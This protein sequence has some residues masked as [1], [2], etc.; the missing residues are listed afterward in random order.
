MLTLPD[1][2]VK[3]L[4]S[5]Q[6]ERRSPAYLLLDQKGMLLDF[7]GNTSA[8]GVENLAKGDLIQHQLSLLA[9]MI[10]FRD[11]PSCLRFVKLGSVSA[12]VH[13]FSDAQ[14]DWVVL[15]DVSQEAEQIRVIQQEKYEAQ[16]ALDTRAKATPGVSG[17]LNELT[18]LLEEPDRELRKA[19]AAIEKAAEMLRRMVDRDTK[20]SR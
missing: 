4:Y 13:L 20:P 14:G 10:P 6:I 12:D 1:S 8:Y 18:L 17:Q 7:G 19:L 15:L 9:G 5:S 2:V 16:T 3:F 11:A